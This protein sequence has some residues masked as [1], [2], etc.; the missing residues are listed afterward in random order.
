MELKTKYHGIKAYQEDE[1]ITFSKGLPG[2][3]DLTKYILFPIEENDIFNILHSIE[4]EDIGFVVI[5]PFL[6]M[7]EYEIDID[8][9][10]VEELH[11]KDQKDVI[12]F[13]TVTINSDVSKITTN[14]KAPIIINTRE[15]L[16][17]Q[18]IVDNSNYLIKYPLMQE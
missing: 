15:K 10:I 14:L 17:E 2:F 7:K 6:V 11:I 18:I 12:V 4:N 13:N 9:P 8:D 16:G 3:E 1:V 5:S